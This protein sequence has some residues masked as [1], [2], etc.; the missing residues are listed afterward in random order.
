MRDETIHLQTPCLVCGDVLRCGYINSVHEM[1]AIHYSLLGCLTGLIIGFV[2]GRFV[3]SY[4]TNP[5]RVVRHYMDVRMAEV[6]YERT[7]PLDNEF[8]VRTGRFPYS[9]DTP[10]SSKH[11]GSGLWTAYVIDSSSTTGKHATVDMTVSAKDS[12][13]G[14]Y[15]LSTKI[16]LEKRWGP[17]GTYF[18]IRSMEVTN[19]G[20]LIQKAFQ[21]AFN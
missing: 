17:F 16:W 19:A 13:L 5:E 8:L 14:P 21:N 20:E 4:S 3:L 15:S 12:E 11:D 7:S 1:K 18:A 6:Q 10:S 9:S 2:G